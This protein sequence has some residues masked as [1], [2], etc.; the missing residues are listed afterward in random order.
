MINQEERNKENIMILRNVTRE[1]FVKFITN[2]KQDSFS[3]TFVAKCDMLDKWNYCYGYWENDE[4]MGAVV[5][6]ISKNKPIVGNLQLLHTFFKHRNKNIG[7]KLCEFSLSY[8][9]DNN[10]KYFRVSADKNAVNFYKKIGFEFVGLQKS[11]SQLSMFKLTSPI[12]K[13]NN[14]DVDD[15]I[16][17]MA[18]KK[19]KGGCIELFKPFETAKLFV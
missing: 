19:G 4:L 17:K 9:F 6:T 15:Y 5:T 13:N 10:C 12:I 11:K 1:Q 16:Y 3:K 18:N 14:F 2:D 7:T 8:A